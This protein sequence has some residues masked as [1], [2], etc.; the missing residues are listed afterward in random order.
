MDGVYWDAVGCV[1]DCLGWRMLMRAYLQYFFDACFD[2]GAS[3]Y[4]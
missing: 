2:F 1:F 3:M 4:D